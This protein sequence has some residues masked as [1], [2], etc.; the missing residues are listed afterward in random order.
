M[1]LPRSVLRR[2]PP[3]CMSSAPSPAARALKRHA[4]T[5]YA[6]S[7]APRKQRRTDS[8]FGFGL[9][10][11]PLVQ[12]PRAPRRDDGNRRGRA[13]S[14]RQ[15]LETPSLKVEKPRQPHRQPIRVEMPHRSMKGGSTN[16]E[17]ELPG[18]LH[19]LAHIHATFST[20]TLNR[21]D[22]SALETPKNTVKNWA[23]KMDV[24]FQPVIEKGR[25]GHQKVTRY[26]TAS[27]SSL[28]ILTFRRAT[29]TLEVASLSASIC[30][31]G[32]GRNE[33]DALNM[34]Y[35][36]LVYQLHSN[37]LVCSLCFS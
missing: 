37:G 27:L 23:S 21:P 32:D 9:T 18:P 29:I 12:P 25:V 11:E 2:L 1:R 26:V 8:D 36:S 3:T 7:E 19:D 30:A 10:E 34:A 33:K 13:P 24:D 5:N 6:L 28:V 15:M 35:T 17:Q 20:T 16:V 31:V 4:S 22:P 14:L